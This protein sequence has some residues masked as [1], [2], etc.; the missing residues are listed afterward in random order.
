MSII[1]ELAH[2]SVKTDRKSSTAV[3]VSIFIAVVLIGFFLI[4][5]SVMDYDQ[6]VYMTETTGGYS[7]MLFARSPEDMAELKIDHRVKSLAVIQR[8]NL[9]DTS[10]KRPKIE[11]NY[12]DAPLYEYE[13]WIELV[14]GRYPENSHELLVSEL[15]LIENP[16]F[17]IGSDVT[18]ADR[19]FQIS[20]SFKEYL[21][22][23]EGTYT[24]FG[25]MDSI[26]TH[27]SG[28]VDLCIWL[29]NERA[30]YEQIPDLV[31]KLGLDPVKLKKDGGL[32]YN[33]GYLESKMIFPG[34]IL[35]PS[36]DVVENMLFRGFVI[37]CLVVLFVMIIYNAFSVWNER[38][39]KQIGL[40]KSCGMSKRQ[41]KRYVV[42]KAL[43]LSLRPILFG[44]AA[45]YLLTFL[46][47]Y[48]FEM[49]HTKY[50]IAYTPM[51]ILKT[52]FI[53]LIR[54]ALPVLCLALLAVIL[55]SLKPARRSSE[56]SVVNAIKSLDPERSLKLKDIRYTSNIERS[57]AKEYSSSYSKTYRGMGIALAVACMICS[58]TLVVRSFNH[59][60][61][62]YNTYDSPYNMNAIV[63]S[64]DDANPEMITQLTQVDGISQLVLYRGN[65]SLKFCERDNPDFLS[66]GK[67][68]AW[69]R[70]KKDK[71]AFDVPVN[72]YGIDD[73][74]WDR[75]CDEH[76]LNSGNRE[77]K[78]S[79]EVFLLDRTPEDPGR[80]YLRSNRISLAGEAINDIHLRREAHPETGLISLEIVDRLTEVPFGIDPMPQRSISLFM[81]LSCFN[82]FLRDNGFDRPLEG[83]RHIISITANEDMLDEITGVTRQIVNKYIPKS[84]ARV[85]SKNDMRRLLQEEEANIKILFIFIQGFLLFVGLSNAYNSFNS[86]LQARRRDFALLRSIGMQEHQLK[87]MLLYEGGFLLRKVLLIFFLLLM[88]LVTLFAYRKKMLFAPWE[89]FTN[90]NF[91]LLF[92]F[93]GINAVGIFA[94]IQ[95]GIGRVLKQEIMK[96]LR[97][98]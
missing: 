95:G 8:E 43:R 16:G 42:Y 36:I 73:S 93:L 77:V 15:F 75:Y 89:I 40:L 63:V 30:A 66:E 6:V 53:P 32:I 59:L 29:E 27:V 35:E 13:R 74:M 60:N 24:C 49:T 45:S 1:R 50:H 80:P 69:A 37:L 14:S 3:S 44:I 47:F 28:P 54:A 19:H 76:G 55:A 67:S 88:A 38:D 72:L 81:P 12:L 61:E 48:L 9:E 5:F 97:E 62:R 17:K 22:S 82:S 92:A 90:L 87:K 20:G 94:A 2:D 86:N 71:K 91:P 56:L 4:V 52:P 83:K 7:A 65:W 46:L 33:T 64:L 58:M 26:K 57:L 34:G 21:Y 11:L 10:L 98:E 18:V 78:G 51:E 84:D 68:T 39:M 70:L 23:F 31:Q 96:S 41:V 79:K 85:Q 25:W